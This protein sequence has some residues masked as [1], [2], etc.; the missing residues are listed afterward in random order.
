MIAAL[1]AAR[2]SVVVSTVG[3]FAENAVRVA[4]ACP[5]GTHYVDV[6]NELVA[7]R[8]VL[9]LDAEAHARGSCL[10]PAAGYGVVALP[11]GGRVRTAGFPSG[12]LEAAHRAGAHTPCELFGTEIAERCGGEITLA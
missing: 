7:V 2:P 1:G 4:K 5:P 12:D 6:S 9:A 3:P 11:E 10:V 8:D